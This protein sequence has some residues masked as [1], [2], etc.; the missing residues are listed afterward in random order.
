[1][2][3]TKQKEQE[4]FQQIAERLRAYSFKQRKIIAAEAGVHFNTLHY[5]ANGMVKHADPRR[6]LAVQAALDKLEA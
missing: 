4:A 1:V 6:L 2:L 5:W 3:M